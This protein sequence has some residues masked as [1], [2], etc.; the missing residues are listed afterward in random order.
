MSKS[1]FRIVLGGAAAIALFPTVAGAQTQQEWRC[2]IDS[3]APSQAIV[4]TEWARKCGLLNNLIP[5]GPTGFV[6]SNTTLDAAAF[7]SIVWAKEYIEKT[8]DRAYAGNSQAYRVNYYYAIAMYDATPMLKVEAEPSGPTVG[9]FKWLATPTTISRARPLY[10][11]FESMQVPGTGI[12]LYPHPTDTS[13]CRLYRDT[14]NDAR[15]DTLYGTGSF[16]VVAQCESSCYAPDQELLFSNGSVPISKAVREQ[17]TDIITLTPDA[18]LDDVQLQTN[19]VYSYTSETRDSEHLLYTITTEHGG[20]LRLTNEHP[21]VNSEGRMVRA[22]DLKLDDELLRQDG[23]R[24]RVV[25]VEKTTHFGKVYNLRPITRDQV[26]NVVVAQGFLV[27]SARYQ[28]EDVGFMNRIILQRSVPE[29]L[30]P[31]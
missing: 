23:T 20:K 14:N 10:P 15:G 29:E 31:Q 18:T 19:H 12:A 22:A 21:V 8:P 24:E 2:N 11:T 5:A 26:T 4:R 1:V 6:S 28:N 13:D 7:P 30:L 9:F 3:L 16:Y 17:Q 27:G 25:S